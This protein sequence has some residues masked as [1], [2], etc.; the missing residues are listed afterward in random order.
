MRSLLFSIRSCLGTPS[1]HISDPLQPQLTCPGT[2]GIMEFRH[3]MPSSFF[4]DVKR[5][6]PLQG[7]VACGRPGQQD[8]ELSVG[9]RLESPP[10]TLAL[11]ALMLRASCSLPLPPCMR[12]TPRP[13]LEGGTMPSS[14]WGR[15]SDSKI[16]TGRPTSRRLPVIT[17][18]SEGGGVGNHFLRDGSGPHLTGCQVWLPAWCPLDKGRQDLTACRALEGGG[19]KPWG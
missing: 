13:R 5:D 9:G 11:P 14:L 8:P 1:A 2:S 16:G 12:W 3:S 4:A 19:R 10:G 18:L 17:L 15:R 7:C 6:S